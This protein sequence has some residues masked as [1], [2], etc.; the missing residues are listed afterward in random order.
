MSLSFGF[1]ESAACIEEAI[2]DAEKLKRGKILFFAAA[3]NQGR[4][5][6]EMFPA[7]CES[8]ISVRGTSHDGSFIPRYNPD[9]W[10]ESQGATLYGTISEN[11]PCDWTCGQL[12]KSGC[13]VA[14]PIVAA[15]A[16]MIIWFVS[17]QK[18]TFVDNE[19]FQRLIRTRKG[20]LSVFR[21]MTEDQDPST[22][23]YLATWQLFESDNLMRKVH[24]IGHGLTRLSK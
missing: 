19:D 1:A 8:V 12:V 18:E 17:C 11:V 10:S 13:S 2:I 23:R 22:R 7:R 24:T 3:N 14:T 5:Q 21:A 4:N 16:S 20:M 15:I 6:K 9:T